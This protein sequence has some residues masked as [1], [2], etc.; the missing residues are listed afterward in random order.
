[1]FAF[2]PVGLI[3]T[4]HF[5]FQELLIASCLCMGIYNVCR[6][7]ML[8]H[9]IGYQITE[10]A[11]EWMRKMTIGCPPCM[12]S[13]WGSLFYGLVIGLDWQ[14]LLFVVCL[15]GLNYFASQFFTE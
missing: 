6:P 14:L 15:S 7:G 10:H 8:L 1:M 3:A 2:A 12:A 5:G 11:P 13:L 9:F 4:L